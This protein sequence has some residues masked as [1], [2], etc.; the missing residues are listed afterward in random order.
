MNISSFHTHTRLCR[1]ASG[2]PADYV[3]AA[4]ED[5]CSALGISDHCP[6]PDGTWPGSRMDLAW[7]GEYTALVKAAAAEAPFPFFWGFECEWH[8]K[9][10]SWYRDYLRSEIGAE[11]LVYGAHWVECGGSFEYIPEAGDQR[12]L[13]PYVDLTIEGLSSGLFDLFAHPDIFLAGFP[14]WDAELKAASRDIIR[15]AISAGLPMEIN[16]LGL[17]KPRV[18]GHEGWRAPYPV[19]EFLELAASEGAVLICNSD[20]HRPQDTL[21]LARNAGIW[22]DSWGLP[23]VDAIEALAFA[24]NAAKA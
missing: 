15:A 10:E 23:Y 12:N 24:K 20:A 14:R 17:T 8:P 9:Y 7:L 5:G 21:A 4:A 19:R 2:D 13:K 3:K 6:Y 18:H 11:Y 22:A 1:H 16:G